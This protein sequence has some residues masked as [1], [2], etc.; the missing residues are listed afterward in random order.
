M[1]VSASAVRFLDVWEIRLFLS[2]YQQISPKDE[3]GERC[4]HTYELDYGFVV[5][6]V[7]S[8]FVHDELYNENDSFSEQ[9]F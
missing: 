1:H 7:R 8:A 3:H 5:R 2:L 9:I 4:V 6:H